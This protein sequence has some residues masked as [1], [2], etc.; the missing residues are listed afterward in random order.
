MMGTNVAAGLA[1]GAWGVLR[2]ESVGSVNRY[3]PTGAFWA[4]ETQEARTIYNQI[5]RWGANDIAEV[6]GNTGLPQRYINTVHSHMFLERHRIAIGPDQWV[7]QR[8]HAYE[9]L[10]N[11]WQNARN[12]RLTQSDLA[13]FRDLF[14]HEYVEHVLMSAGMPYNSATRSAWWH[15]PVT[16]EWSYMFPHPAAHGAHDMAPLIGH[17]DPWRHWPIVITGTGG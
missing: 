2:A 5:R 6:A 16:Q 10:G 9:D 7:N 3:G 11:L 13:E 1:R 12:G 14:A 4:T 8:F 15:D 17:V